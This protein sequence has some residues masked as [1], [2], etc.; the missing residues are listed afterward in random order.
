MK[1]LTLLSLLFFLHTAYADHAKW[2]EV[3]CYQYNQAEVDKAMEK[4]VGNTKYR[5]K[6]LNA[7]ID[8]IKRPVRYR[9]RT[10]PIKRFGLAVENGDYF[11]SCKPIQ[12]KSHLILFL[13]Y[14]GS[15]LKSLGITK[16]KIQNGKEV[17]VSNNLYA[18]SESKNI[19]ERS[20]DINN[21]EEACITKSCKKEIIVYKHPAAFKDITTYQYPSSFILKKFGLG[22]TKLSDHA[23]PLE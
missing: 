6:Q 13:Y 22:G 15:N 19:F 16:T 1:R 23:I 11:T 7:M 2:Q 3:T 20:G 5:N 17:L 18:Y 8:K 14:Q 10:T 12:D 4:I 21:S 9:I